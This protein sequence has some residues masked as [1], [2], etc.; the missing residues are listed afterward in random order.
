MFTPDSTAYFLLKVIVYDPVLRQ[1][2]SSLAAVDLT[3][4]GGF[5]VDSPLNF[6]FSIVMNKT[7][8]QFLGATQ[9][10][11]R[12][13]QAFEY[14]LVGPPQSTPIGSHFLLKNLTSH[15]AGSQE[16]EYFSSGTFGVFVDFFNAR[17]QTLLTAH[18]SGVVQIAGADVTATNTT[19]SL[20]ISLTFVAL[21]FSV[22]QLRNRDRRR[23]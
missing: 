6:V 19:N 13:E 12:P 14:P 23:M 18:S 15:W 11:I 3:G 4:V 20:I 17:N 2:I 22:I 1:N 9:I 5:A 21:F 8:M 7:A 10:G 16:V